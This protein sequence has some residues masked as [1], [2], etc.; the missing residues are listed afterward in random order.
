MKRL[1]NWMMCGLAAMMC[2]A[3]SADVEVAG[4]LDE[5]PQIFPDYAEVTV[6]SNIAPLDFSFLGDEPCRLRVEGRTIKGRGGLFAFGA[7]QWKSLMQKD[8]L[9]LTVLVQKD[10][11]WLSCK[12]FHIYVKHEPIDRYLSY[13]LLPPGYQGWKEMGIYQRDLESYRQSAIYENHLSGENCVNCHT[14]C[15]RDPQ[16][17]VFHARA[18]FGGTFLLADGELEKLN[19]KTDSTISALVYPYWHPDGKHVAF[20]TNKTLQSFFAHSPNRI[21]VFDSASDVVVYNTETHE[22]A[23]SPLTKSAE[24]LETFPTFSPDGRWL[25]FCAA[26]AASIEQMP[27]DCEKAKYAVMRV[28]YYAATESFGD[29]LEM[30]FDAPAEGLSA[31]FPR[32]S[33]D[34]RL[35]AFTLHGFGNFSIWHKDADVCILDLETGSLT[36]CD[37][38]NSDDVDSWHCWSGSSRWMVVSSRRDDGLYTRPYIAWVAPDG[39][40]SKPFLLPQKDPA[41]YYRDLMVSYNLPEFTTSKV[42]LGRHRVARTMRRSAGTDVKT[43]N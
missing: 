1:A 2:M 3:C 30:V 22:I 9:E 8:S 10:G 19:T 27:R 43:K 37:A 35:L 18:D 4:A 26:E 20:S 11:K 32:I 7:R 31:S 21:E 40:A 14:Y 5:L 13:R 6:P 17:M 25:Y 15:G 23:W 24:R 38:L 41:R 28:A 16:K 33:P 39:T 12:P 29:S 34:G 36:S 42:S